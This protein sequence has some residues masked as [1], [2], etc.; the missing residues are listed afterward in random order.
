MW[1]LKK[2]GVG[3]FS[4]L[5]CVVSFAQT[6]PSVVISPTAPSSADT[7]TMRIER[8]T[9]PVQYL[10]NSYRVSQESNRLRVTLGA[11]GPFPLLPP[12]RP[13]IVPGAQFTFVELGK[14]PAGSYQL[15]VVAPGANNVGEFAI[16]TGLSLVVSDARALK[17]AP[18]VRLNYADHWWNPSESGW[19][20]FIWHDNLDRVLAAWFT[21]GSD[22]RAEWY[23]IQ[24][25]SW[26]SFNIYEGQVIKTTGPG[27]STF[28][29]GSTVQTQVVGTATLNFTDANNGTFAYTLNGVT[30]TKNITR[31]KP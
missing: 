22:N 18:Y 9:V 29:P 8:G 13:P 27:F 11:I 16:A 6:A 5:L 19:G 17:T 7:I 24:A 28:V 14:L 4:L 25:G 1:H 23:S 31:F 10:A 15:D 30:Q 2:I 20:L 21:Y 12:I 3:A 26:V